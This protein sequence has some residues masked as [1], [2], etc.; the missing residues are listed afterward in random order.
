MM[1]GAARQ[2]FETTYRVVCYSMGSA[3]LCAIVPIFGGLIGAI[4]QI[5]ALIFGCWNGHETTLGKAV[6]AVMIPLA[7]SCVLLIGLVMLI[8]SI[9]STVGS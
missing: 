7:V 9:V 1:V 4:L 6:L 8:M 2:P 3:A 5:V